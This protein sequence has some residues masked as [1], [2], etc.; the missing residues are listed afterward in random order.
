MPT[1][2]RSGQKTS[3]ASTGAA[4]HEVRDVMWKADVE[5]LRLVPGVQREAI[6]GFQADLRPCPMGLLLK[7]YWRG[8]REETR[9]PAGSYFSKNA[10]S[11]PTSSLEPW[12]ERAMQSALINM[13]LHALHFTSKS[14]V[15]GNSSLGVGRRKAE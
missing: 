7:I 5:G 9:R 3:V 4:G 1:L 8:A 10:L 6:G 12:A 14:L 13:Y 2:S 11:V 15:L